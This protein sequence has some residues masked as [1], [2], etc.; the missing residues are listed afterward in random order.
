MSKQNIFNVNK[1]E[2]VVFRSPTKQIY[3]NLIWD[4]VGKNWTKAEP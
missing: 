2:M 4:L 3:K 1:T